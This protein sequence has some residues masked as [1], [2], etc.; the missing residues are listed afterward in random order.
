MKPEKRITEGQ[1]VAAGAASPPDFSPT[2]PQAG[3]RDSRNDEGGGLIPSPEEEFYGGK[4]DE[5]EQADFE[6]AL[7]IEGLD[8]EIALLRT[9]LLEV[10]A[11][12]PERLDLCMKLADSIARLVSARYRMTKNQKRSLKDTLTRVL[13]EVAIPL[14]PVAVRMLLKRANGGR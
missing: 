10:M 8:G 4:L 2:R 7:A 3:A 6:K 11:R 14:G 12:R 9:K 1:Q 13:T 5:S